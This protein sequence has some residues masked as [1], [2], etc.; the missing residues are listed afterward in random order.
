MPDVSQALYVITHM[1]DGISSPLSYFAAGKWA[2]D[3]RMYRIVLL[4]FSLALLAL[5]DYFSLEHDVIAWISSQK[6]IVRY[7][8]YFLLSLICLL[9]RSVGNV[10]FLYSN[11]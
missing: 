8:V 9:F 1:F 4:G 3:L 7:P 11:F 10:G 5:Y 2:M 6:R